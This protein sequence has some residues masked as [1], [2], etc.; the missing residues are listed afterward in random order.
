MKKKQVFMGFSMFL[1]LSLF[2]NVFVYAQTKDISGKVTDEG[3]LPMPGVSVFIKN[4]TTG[5]VT[6][7]DGLY[8]ISGVSNSSTLVFSFIG[9]ETQELEVGNVSELNVT[10][11]TQAY[12]LAEVVAVGYGTQKKANLTG[13]V[14][15]VTAEK[16]EAKPI[17]N[18]GQ[19]LQGLIPNL[20]VTVLVVTKH[21]VPT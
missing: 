11:T 20:N 1:V 16:L 21:V 15:M 12:G 19:G 17:T 2:L 8:S 4:T 3:G 14:D 6:D 10:L 7:A 9:M 5:T 18:V 13:S